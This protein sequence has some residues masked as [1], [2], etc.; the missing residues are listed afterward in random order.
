MFKLK[1][2][3]RISLLYVI[4]GY[5]WII[6]SDKAMM[7]FAPDR[8]AI[9]ILSISKGWFYVTT[10]GIL[11]YIL[12][13]RDSIK[14]QKHN[15][16][17]KA[18]KEKAEE[19]DRLKSRFLANLSHELR[20]P[21]NAI[22]GFADLLNTP[23]LIDEKRSQYVQII[24]NKSNNLLQ[25]I[26]NLI[27]SARIQEESYSLYIDKVNLNY[28]CEKV[29]TSILPDI[30]HIGKNNLIFLCET[31]PKNNNFTINTDHVKLELII[32]N[33]LYNAIKYTTKGTILFGYEIKDK[34]VEFF[35]EDSGIGISEEDQV[36][37]FERFNQGNDEKNRKYG[38]SGLGLSICKAFVEILGG[39]IW[40]VSKQGKGSTFYFT[41]PA[42]TPSTI[43]KNT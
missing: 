32:K 35:V 29:Y 13:R 3:I 28:L 34:H 1:P 31:D 30:S 37:I 12:I 16:E 42:N 10:T 33:L 9:K 4:L 11:L 6:F 20:S 36:S 40:L 14:N 19:S 25:L 15:Q 17:L 43:T 21:M 23:N 38:G 41:L 8:E 7:L 24:Y 18:A 2:E 26:N 5:L 39:K 22:L 27:E